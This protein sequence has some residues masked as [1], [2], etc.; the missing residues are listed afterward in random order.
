MTFIISKELQFLAE[1]DFYV[2]L[3]PMHCVTRVSRV[4]LLWRTRSLV[5]GVVLCRSLTH[6]PN[7][8]PYQ[9][10]ANVLNS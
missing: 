1:Y 3:T 8:A 5:S 10:E 2:K 9:I 6:H 7:N 4:V